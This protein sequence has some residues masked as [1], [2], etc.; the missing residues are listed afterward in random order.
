MRFRLVPVDEGFFELFSASARNV[1]DAATRLRELL[2]DP[3][4]LAKMHAGVV[5]FERKGDEITHDTLTRLSRSFVTPFD[6]ED[7]HA[8]AEELD[9]VV[10][11]ILEVAALLEVVDVDEILPELKEQADILVTMAEQNVALLDRLPR[12]KGVEPYLDAIDRLESEGDTINRRAQ[13]RLFS[14]EMEALEVLKWKDIIRAMEAAL[15]TIE[16]ISDVV[17]SIVLKHA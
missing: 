4:N 2:Q 15:N 14:G 11:D 10:D 16:D 1:L 9:D 12:M 7:I 6:R 3:A 8:L 17:E 13:V 5:E